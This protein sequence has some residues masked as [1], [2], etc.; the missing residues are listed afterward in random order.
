MSPVRTSILALLA[1]V[2]LAENGRLGAQSLQRLESASVRWFQR[3]TTNVL[4]LDGERLGTVDQVLVTGEG[5]VATILPKSGSSAVVLESAKGGLTGEASPADVK[6]VEVRLVVAADAPFGAREL[7][8]ASP[9]G[10]SNPLTVNVSELLE[11][12]EREP[13][14]LPA[15]AQLIVLPAAVSGVIHASTE[16]DLF[17]FHAR[18]GERILF[19]VQANRTGSPLDPTL[20]LLDA[21]GKEIARSEDVHGLDPF[22]DFTAPAE[23]DYFAKIQDLRFQG[24]GNYRYRLVAGTLPYLDFLFP[25]GGR[26][27]TTVDVGLKGLNL[28]GRE[29]LAVAIAADAPVGLQDVRLATLRGRSN[30]L[31]FEAGDLPEQMETEPNGTATNANVITVPGVVNGRIGEPKDSDVFRF[32]AIADQKLV[33]EVRARQFGSPLDALLTLSDATGAVLQRNDDSNGLDARIEFDAKKD[34][35]Y[36]LSIRDLTD[37]GGERFGYR[38]TLRPPDTEPDFTVRLAQDRY[39]V[40]AGGHTAVRCDID[41]R[42]GF[43]GVVRVT[44]GILPPGVSAGTLM[45]APDGPAS[46]WLVVS[47]RPDAGTGHFRLDPVAT[48][49]A[50]GRTVTKTASAPSLGFLSVIPAAPFSVDVATLAAG[51]EQ[52]S[53]GSFDIS[54][55]R[56]AG[57]TGEIRVLGEDLSGVG[58][59]AVTVP[60]GQSRA[61]LAFSAAYNSEVSTRPVMIRAEATVDGAV[62]AEHVAAPV[63]LTVSRIP[64]FLTAMLPGSPFFRTDPFKLAVVA[65]PTNSVSPANTTEFVVKA[66]RRGVTNEIPLRIDG[67]PEGVFATVSPV[68]ANANLA[69]IRLVVSEKV[70]VKEHVFTV[71]GTATADDR[72]WRPRTQP[73]TLVV[74]APEKETTAVAAPVPGIVK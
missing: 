2:C 71:V 28:E 11:L 12:T 44:G 6:S 57:F 13:N 61:K 15:E 47:A 34:A 3:G 20:L 1:A 35:E 53:G 68:P 56:R 52:N 33:V 59:P 32:K 46:G 74:S 66:D 24:G 23:A 64:L 9:S 51:A 31:P 43:N 42:N 22:L 19:D 41:R 25:F 21:A 16:A 67:L 30:P 49:E 39:R 27:G 38:M 29:K 5:V 40:H 26:R 17:R 50:S 70:A 69:T 36:L 10:I 4:N 62:V 54:V 14:N 65:L 8:V 63:P 18:S 72:T 73:V 55:V 60:P 45:F 58:L 37:R 7:R 48:G